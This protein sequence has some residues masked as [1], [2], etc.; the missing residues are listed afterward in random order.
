[1]TLADSAGWAFAVTAVVAVL[2]RLAGALTTGGT[3][4][5]FVVGACVSGEFGLHGLAVLGTF[6]V[7]GTVATRIGW[8]KK[9]ARGTAEAGE[10]R[11]DWK[12]VLGKGGVAAAIALVSLLGMWPI[13]VSWMGVWMAFSGAVA[14][15]LAD[16]LGTEVGTLASALPR[17]LPN[18]RR[19]P[20]GT[21]GAVSLLGMAGAAVGAATVALVAMWLGI[22][23]DAPMD[24]TSNPML[25]MEPL[26][27]PWWLE[28]AGSGLL[29]LTVAG[30]GAS[31][32]ESLAVGWGLRA[33][34]FVRNVLTTS[35][36]AVIALALT[37]M[38]L[39]Q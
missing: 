37:R 8:E 19:V 24:T 39:S 23:A 33:P 28:V 17:S 35:A 26:H 2:A 29:Q 38:F 7:V 10:G 22:W 15:A 5:G 11:R 20:T 1:M 32:L 13:V 14:A 3:I 25:T 4:A 12:R 9:K 18:F 6:F 21:P 27:A 30:V 31:L 36:G 16:T 34:G